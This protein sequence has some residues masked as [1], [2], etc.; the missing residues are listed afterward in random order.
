MGREEREGQGVGGMEGGK[1][2]AEESREVDHR[3]AIVN[4][5]S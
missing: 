5:Q 2:K 3:G 4:S 1:G